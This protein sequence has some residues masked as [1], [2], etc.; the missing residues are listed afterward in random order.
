[1]TLYPAE[2]PNQLLLILGG[3]NLMKN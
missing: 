3:A 2:L 1:M